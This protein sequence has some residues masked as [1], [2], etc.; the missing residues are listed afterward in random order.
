[1][2]FT[3][4]SAMPRVANV[5]AVNRVIRTMEHASRVVNHTISNLCVLV[6]YIF[7]SIELN[8]SDGATHGASAANI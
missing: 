3:T 1:M 4:V 2:G 7:F 8:M 6:D 5:W